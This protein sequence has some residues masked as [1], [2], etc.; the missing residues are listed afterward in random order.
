MFA[1]SIRPG[2]LAG[3]NREFIDPQAL[4]GVMLGNCFLRICNVF[5]RIQAMRE[6]SYRITPLPQADDFAISQNGAADPQCLHR[7]DSARP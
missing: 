5:I 6:N 1:E 2:C 7:C 3:L 4:I